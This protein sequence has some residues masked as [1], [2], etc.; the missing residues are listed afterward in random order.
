MVTKNIAGTNT[1]ARSLL[2]DDYN[3]IREQ[4]NGIATHNIWGLDLDGTLQ[5]CGGVGGLLAVAK[6]NGLHVALY[7]ANGNVSD[8]MST[9]GAIAAHYEYS[10]FGEPLVSSD[11]NFTHQFSTK[12]WF[13]STHLYEYQFRKYNASLGRWMNRD[14]FVEDQIGAT[15]LFSNNNAIDIYDDFGLVPITSLAKSVL[16]DII[17][18]ILFSVLKASYNQ[19]TTGEKYYFTLGSS[20]AN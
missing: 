15:L 20:A 10:P 11:G 17:Y 4:D 3:I 13:G 5:G 9:T 6:T 1:V 18:D 8:Y 14:P 7:D 16:K 2:W 12:P 19:I